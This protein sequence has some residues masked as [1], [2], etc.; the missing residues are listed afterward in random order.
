MEGETDYKPDNIER[1]DAQK[2]CGNENRRA[3]KNARNEHQVQ[4]RRK[5]TS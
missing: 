4:K 2:Q 5:K 1:T 3:K